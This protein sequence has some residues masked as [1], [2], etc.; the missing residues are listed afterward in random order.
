MCTLQ[1]DAYLRPSKC[2]SSIPTDMVVLSMLQ[3]TPSPPSSPV[4]VTPASA[5]GKR[6]RRAPSHFGS[7]TSYRTDPSEQFMD[8]EELVGSLEQQC[9]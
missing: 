6:E 1:R 5:A 8:F 2:L 3:E 9:E 7:V 4:V